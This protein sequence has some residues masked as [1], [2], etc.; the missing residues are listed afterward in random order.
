MI[1]TKSLDD[2]Q[3]LIVYK[4][5]MKMRKIR[6]SMVEVLLSVLQCQWFEEEFNVSGSYKLLTKGGSVG[7]QIFWLT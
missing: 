1:S 7:V 4:Q 5:M 6:A 2:E 3:V